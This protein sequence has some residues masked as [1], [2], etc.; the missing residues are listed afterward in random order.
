VKRLAFILLILLVFV[1]V[2]AAGVHT[3]VKYV[4]AGAIYL[5]AGRAS[6]ISKGD[7]VE[8]LRDDKLITLLTI[9]YVADNSSSCNIGEGAASIQT[10]DHALVRGTGVTSGAGVETEPTELEMEAES[11]PVSKR[12]EPTRKVNRLAGRIGFEYLVQDDREEYDYDYAQ[13]SLNVRLKISE[14]HG[15]YYSASLRMRTRKTIRNRESFSTP[16]S[17][18]SHRIYEAALRYEKPDSPIEYGVGR[19]VAQELRGIGYLDGAYAKYKG[20]GRLAV[21]VFGGTEP[22]LENTDFQTEVTKGGVYAAYDHRT[23]EGSRTSATLALAGSYQDG[24]VD[25]EFVYQQLNYYYGSRLSLYEST[26]INIYRDWLKDKESASMALAGSQVNARYS[27]ARLIAFSLGYDNRRNFYTY[28]ARS[29]PDS[30]FDDA[31]RE[32]W[33][34][35]VDFRFT[36]QISSELGGSLRTTEGRSVNATSSWLRVNMSDVLNSA[37]SVTA[38]ARAYSTEYSDGVQPSLTVSKSLFRVL[39]TSLQFGANSYTLSST[40]TKI[41]QNWSRLALDLSLGR[42]YYASLDA[43]AARGSHQNS[44]TISLALGLR[45]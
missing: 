36:R 5:D 45:L 10:G 8:I 9:A 44:N 21:G 7:T 12:K 34:G 22:D 3:S 38:L 6:G 30:L 32:G 39:S 4:S 35:S 41:N 24:Q 40:D 15:S 31:L 25:R 26:E 2:R 23:S 18:T 1:T 27:P 28:D 13:P 37:V 42:R 20:G 11:Q 43:Q 29:V 19:I 14:I 16:K 33:R 17:E